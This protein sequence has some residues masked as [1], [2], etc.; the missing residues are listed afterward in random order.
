M[1]NTNIN[2][3]IVIAVA[4]MDEKG[5]KDGNWSVMLFERDWYRLRS[6]LFEIVEPPIE[7]CRRAGCNA[8]VYS[9]GLCNLH[10]NV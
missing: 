4:I 2:E 8:Q 3:S 9:N 5:R 10:F 6:I 1:K 7:T